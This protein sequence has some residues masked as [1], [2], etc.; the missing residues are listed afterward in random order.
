MNQIHNYI[1][2][3]V[4]VL[5]GLIPSH[6]QQSNPGSKQMHESIEN[7]QVPQQVQNDTV[8]L[9]VK[10]GNDIS[11]PIDFGF[12]Q[13]TKKEDVTSASSINV[14]DLITYN[15][16]QS[17]AGFVNGFFPGTLGINNI[18]GLGNVLFVID[19]IPGRDISSLTAD[20]IERISVLKDVNALTLYGSQGRNGA[21]VITTKR[22]VIGKNRIN[23]STSYHMK[24]PIAYPTYLGSAEYMQLY[25]EARLNDGLT[26]LYDEEAIQ[27]TIDGE[28]PYRYPDVDFYSADY[29]KPY[30]SQTNVSTSFTGGNEK[31]RYF[32]NMDHKFNGT[33]ENLNPDVNKGQNQFKVRGNLDFKINNW[34]SSSVDIMTYL[35]NSRSAHAS[36]LASGATF[37][38]N[39]YAPLI[40][41]SYASSALQGQLSA[42]RTYD[43]NILGGS[44]SFTG[45]TPIADIYAKG[46]LRA[47]ENI[48]QVAN[49]I[50][51]DL[52][53][54][55]EGLSAKTYVSLDYSDNYSLSI[56][57]RYN[58]YQPTWGVDSTGTWENDSIVALDALG[59]ADRK[60][61]TEN[62][63]TNGFGV[64]Y[65]A[66]A[67]LNYIKQLNESHSFNAVLLGY[68]NSLMAEDRTQLDKQSHLALSAVYSYRSKIF[69]DFSAAYSHSVKLDQGNRGGLSPTF[70]LAYLLSEEGFLKDNAIIDYLKL[71]ASGGVLK[72]DINMNGYFLYQEVYDLNSGVVSWAD[73][74]R[75][76][77]RTT[78]IN[79]RNQN[80]TFEDRT[81]VNIGIETSLLN[82]L[83]LE[84]NYFQM[85]FGNQVTQLKSTKYPSFYS[86]F[87]PYSNYDED[88]FNGVEINVNF[89]KSIGDL[90]ANFGVNYLNIN[91]E[92]V[93]KD[94]LV[95][96]DYLSRI[97]QPTSAILGLVADGFYQNSD[98]TDAGELISTLP[99]PQ[100]GAVK[101]GDIKYVNQNDD[102]LID[103]ND[104]TFI[105]K[106]MFSHALGINLLLKYKS[107]SLFMLCTG[108]FGAEGM[109]NGDYY[110]VDGTDKYSEIVLDRWTETTSE[111]ATYP[112][113]SSNA[114]NNNFRNSTFWLYDKSSF[115]LDR[116]QLTY[117]LNE[118]V[119]NKLG[120]N[121]LSVNVAGVNLAKFAPNKDYLELNIG[122]IPQFRYYMV[123]LRTSL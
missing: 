62:V 105:G 41:S 59:E 115:D 53:K 95:E 43:G 86:D 123:G 4:L 20:E 24:V 22:G 101:A 78:L 64:R 47:V 52:S 39:L 99:V 40:P 76:S 26:E 9:H 23:V 75:S 98:F 79:G 32:V 7:L 63:S 100:F 97:G 66:Y 27:N 80:L 60:D 108:R 96:F 14:A 8:V 73:G 58:F 2:L 68:T 111:S 31:V 37:R 116:I 25:N 17:I 119:C 74:A 16:T 91:S 45:I 72:T 110:W 70:G 90:S 121:S 1:L 44:T 117:E 15:N 34:I 82:S 50:T 48:S 114:N 89:S 94:E 103:N 11:Q 12:M 61:Q 81:D 54:I 93:L 69:A 88:I 118:S 51:F 56:N 87:S 28:N 71:K 85:T 106:S 49:T 19:G 5:S 42:I 109:L 120:L 3:G 67:Q 77:S 104:R 30:T 10:A 55:T 102:N 65:G 18:R 46:Y 112:R 83:F 38:P 21:I 13:K 92:V 84:L 57:N 107:V 122:G 113:L 35:N 29:L 33:L 36:V 6:A